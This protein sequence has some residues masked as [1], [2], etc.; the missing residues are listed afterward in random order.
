MQCRRAIWRSCDVRAH[1]L[2]PLLVASVRF[3]RGSDASGT[4]LHL[5]CAG[6]TELSLGP[7]PQ[8]VNDNLVRCSGAVALYSGN[9]MVHMLPRKDM[10]SVPQHFVSAGR[11]QIPLVGCAELAPGDLIRLAYLPLLSL[12]IDDLEH[13]AAP[14]D[15]ASASAVDVVPDESSQNP[16][17]EPPLEL[18]AR[19]CEEQRESFVG[20]LCTLP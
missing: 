19:L 2:A 7:E 17:C 16:K 6:R 8:L 12:A 3:A 13:I 9:F 18:L 5:R 4:S 1:A 14:P 10:F 15:P 20:V 11:Q